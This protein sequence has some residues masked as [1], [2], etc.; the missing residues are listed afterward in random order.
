ML[1]PRPQA[2][3]F[4]ARLRGARSVRIG[5]HLNPDG[6]AIGSALALMHALD[7]MGVA[8]EVLCTHPAP[9]NLRFLPGVERVV[10]APSVEADLAVLL[11]LD[12]LERLGG[13]R[14]FFEGFESM[15]V[16]DHHLPHEAPGDLR[17]IDT[18][19]PATALILAELLLDGGIEI[20]PEI[21]L[22][23]MT[24]IVTDTGSFRYRNTTSEALAMSSEL[25]ARGG[26]IVRVCEEVYQRR[27]LQAVRLLGR[28][29]DRMRLEDGGKVAWTV[30]RH[31]DFSELAAI[32]AHSEGIVNELLFID[33]VRVAAVIREPEPGKVRASLRSRDGYDVNQVAR[34]FGGGGH[35]NAAGC[36]FQGPIEDAERR[37]SAALR[38]AVEEAS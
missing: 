34:P 26:D 3:A 36:T 12:A 8:S 5:T 38:K 37:L 20:T 11:D 29:L 32:E 24:G 33:T 27:P 18:S 30:L 28:A 6:D 15:I 31:E 2:E 19:S 14:R 1:S 13:V 25:Q 21:A 7:R 4:V 35:R 22:C 17:I 10:Q 9:W 16:V 23:L